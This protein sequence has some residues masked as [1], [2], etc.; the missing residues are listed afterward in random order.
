MNHSEA[1]C[2]V[3]FRPEIAAGLT[4]FGDATG[5]LGRRARTLRPS[6]QPFGKVFLYSLSEPSLRSTNIAASTATCE[7]IYQMGLVRR[8]EGVFEGTKGQRLGGEGNAR[9]DRGEATADFVDARKNRLRELVT[10]ERNLDKDWFGIRTEDRGSINP[11]FGIL[12]DEVLR[13][14]VG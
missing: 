5:W 10:H 9:F 12:L 11:G 6:K 14:T 3:R 1:S 13:V 8:R 2:W 4:V 7:L